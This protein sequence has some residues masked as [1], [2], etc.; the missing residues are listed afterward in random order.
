MDHCRRR[1]S[2]ASWMVN[3]HATAADIPPS[4]NSRKECT[5]NFKEMGVGHT[6]TYRNI[7]AYE[8]VP[9]RAGTSSRSNNIAVELA[10]DGSLMSVLFPAIVLPIEWSTPGSTMRKMSDA[11]AEIMN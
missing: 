8:F 5:S 7:M 3:T 4:L 2:R 9:L 1:R 11:I 10:D 6:C